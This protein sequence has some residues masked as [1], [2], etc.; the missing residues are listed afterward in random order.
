[1]AIFVYLLGVYIA[2]GIFIF[3]ILHAC[4]RKEIWPE[5]KKHIICS[6][7]LWPGFMTYFC[8]RMVTDE[9]FFG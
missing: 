9:K 7:V 6:A 5:T 2:E 8:Y 1:M 4:C 3:S